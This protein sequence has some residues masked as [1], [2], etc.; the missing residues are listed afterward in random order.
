MFYWWAGGLGR[1]EIS[2]MLAVCLF[3]WAGGGVYGDIAEAELPFSKYIIRCVR[4]FP[5][6]L[7]MGLTF[8]DEFPM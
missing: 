4:C 8:P 2:I 6:F 7:P 3:G 5:P 1:L